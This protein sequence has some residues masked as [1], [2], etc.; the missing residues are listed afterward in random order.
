MKRSICGVMLGFVLV[1]LS[2]TASAQSVSFGYQYQRIGGEDGLNMPLGFN[3]DASVPF[4]AGNVSVIGQF[5]WSRKSVEGIVEGILDAEGSTT[6]SVFGGGIRWTAPGNGGARPFLQALLG[7][8]HNS[9][10]CTFEGVELCESFTGNN[11]LLQLGGGVA[12]PMSDRVSLVGQADYRR[13]FVEE[14]GTN[15]FRF[16]AG[17]RIGM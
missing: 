15:L 11:L 4:G 2:G 14:A 10:S 8:L 3:V 16:V 1:A 12:V 13:A 17:I 9:E 5:D 7:V 6:L